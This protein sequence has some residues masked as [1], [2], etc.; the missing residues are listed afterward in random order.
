MLSTLSAEDLVPGDH[1]IRQIKAF[2]DEALA[3]LDGELGAMY[4]DRGRPSVP[5]EVLLK[6]S[7]LMALYSVRMDIR[8]RPSTWSD[9]RHC[10]S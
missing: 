4:A 5:P 3:E 1:P 2:V 7:V 8:R 6:A 10:R 9:G